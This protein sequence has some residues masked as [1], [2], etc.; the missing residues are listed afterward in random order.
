[1]KANTLIISPELIF[2]NSL[3]PNITIAERNKFINMKTQTTKMG[4]IN[5]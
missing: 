3:I 5:T 4:K 2:Y 1:M